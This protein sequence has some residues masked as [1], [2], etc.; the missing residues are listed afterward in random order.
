MM[1]N[2]REDLIVIVA[3]YQD[4]MVRFVESNPG[5]SSRFNKKLFFDDYTPEQLLSIVERMCKQSDYR[6]DA[7]GAAKLLRLFQSAYRRR[8]RTFGNARLARNCFEVVTKNLA[9]R[10]VSL[11]SHDRDILMAIMAEDVP[12]LPEE[13][14]HKS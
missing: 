1:E 11:K 5:L 7:F 2:H 14:G 3:G 13:F 4:E 10:I 9:N 8:D 12:D 6:L